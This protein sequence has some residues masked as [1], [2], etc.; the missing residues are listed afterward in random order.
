MAQNNTTLNSAAPSPAPANNTPSGNGGSGDGPIPPL[1]DAGRGTFA[2]YSTGNVPAHLTGDFG[3]EESGINALRHDPIYG[4]RQPTN[5][6][7]GTDAAR[8]RHDALAAQYG[9][10][11][12]ETGTGGEQAADFGFGDLNLGDEVDEDLIL[13]GDGEGTDTDLVSADEQEGQGEPGQDA[14][15]TTDLDTRFDKHP[16]FQELR[17]KAQAEAE[18]AAAAESRL[19]ELERY[20]NTIEVLKQNQLG[21]DAAVQEF[22]AHQDAVKDF[23]A[24]WAERE[25]ELRNEFRDDA[26]IER[27]RDYAERLFN[28]QQAEARA[29]RRTE[30]MEQAYLATEKNRVL[31]EVGTRFPVLA[32]QVQMPTGEVFTGRQIAESVYDNQMAVWNLYQQQGHNVPM[33]DL[34]AI[35]ST[36]GDYMA[37]LVEAERQAAVQDH[38]TRRGKAAQQPPAAGTGVGSAPRT[39]APPRGPLS[40]RGFFDENAKF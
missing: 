26:E 9:L 23:E 2:G 15:N 36:V 33:P 6:A 40:G 7:A 14:G 10:G 27:E 31:S 21:D 34:S 25:A 18:R 30:R 28:L 13:P 29:E 19:A 5:P 1:S 4:E 24:R 8:A 38:L 16:R 39:P 3:L 37:K 22:M 35:A 32:R 12:G 17:A 11:S 20:Q